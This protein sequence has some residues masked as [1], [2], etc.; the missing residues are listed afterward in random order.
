MSNISTLVVIG[1]EVYGDVF[2]VA[3]NVSSSGA[4]V[5]MPYAPPLGTIVTV[6][7]QYGH[8]DGEDID[9]IVLRAE[10]THHHYVNLSGRSNA[11]IVGLRFVEIVGS[12]R[13]VP[14]ERIQ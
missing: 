11:R 13:D 12:G 10:V 7:F 4:L 3:R 8:D 2:A 9:E 6:H 1:S 5:E 14:P